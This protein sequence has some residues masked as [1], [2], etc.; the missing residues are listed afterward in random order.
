MTLQLIR[1]ANALFGRETLM[2]G[3]DRAEG[4]TMQKLFRLGSVCAVCVLVGACGSGAGNK[5]AAHS[6]APT[7]TAVTAL[8]A[9]T[10]PSILEVTSG[11][12]AAV[13]VDFATI[14]KLATKT[15]DI[16]EPFEK[17]N[18]AFK[19]VELWTLLQGAGVPA[20]AKSVHLT[21]LDDYA[22]DLSVAD[23]KSGGVIVATRADGT[24]MPLDHGGPI[25]LVFA[26]G[27]AAGSNPDQW[28]WSIAKISAQ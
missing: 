3:V 24:P 10:G 16:F 1:S 25:R 15:Y 18:M 23:L 21:A 2:T 14:D 5:Q 11:S 28:I 8:A 12:S 19:G 13:G 6:S 7:I 26:D 4:T 27:V 20:T 22:V 17:K 9:P